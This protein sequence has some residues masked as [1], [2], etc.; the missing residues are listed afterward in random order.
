MLHIV[1][2]QPE[3]PPNTGNIMRLCANSGV[4]L[5]LV[6]PLG[7]HLD[8]ARLKRAGLDYR[9]LA[10]V[11]RYTDWMSYLERNPETRLWAFSTRG[12]RLYTAARFRLGDGLLFGP[13]TRG[14]PDEVLE[15]IGDRR[16]LRLPMQENSRSLN[17]SNTVAIGLYEALRQLEFSGLA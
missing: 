2:Y 4:R 12:K 1:L 3:I 10:V 11:T 9:D 13:E 5:H 7:F 8:E 15:K 6:E 17:L 14:L 16:T